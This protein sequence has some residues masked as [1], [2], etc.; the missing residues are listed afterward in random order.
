MDSTSTHLKPPVVSLSVL[1]ISSSC[2]PPVVVDVGG[3]RG[4]RV[5][6]RIREQHAR[7]LHIDR[8][9][10]DRGTKMAQARRVLRG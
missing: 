4:P 2:T 10:P 7:F 3:A 6:R 8:Q 9:K 5:K 1:M